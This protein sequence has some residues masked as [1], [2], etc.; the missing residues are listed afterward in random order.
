MYD[1]RNDVIKLMKE[2]SESNASLHQSATALS[3]LL[4]AYF[5][6]DENSAKK[7]IINDEAKKSEKNDVSESVSSV[8]SKVKIIKKADENWPKGYAKIERKLS[9]AIAND[10]TGKTVAYFRE[11]LCRDYDLENGDYVLLNIVYPY[12]P[13]APS[14]QR[15]KA[16]I[17]DLVKHKEPSSIEV[18]GPAVVQEKN[19]AGIKQKIVSRDINGNSLYDVSGVISY[20]I[21]SD[22]VNPGDS[23]VLAWY[24]GINKT[25][26]VRWDYSANDSNADFSQPK[27]HSYY[28]NKDS[29]KND[30][31]KPVYDFDLKHQKVA[32]VAADSALLK[33]IDKVVIS[34]NGEY[35][36]VSSNIASSALADKLRGYP[37]IIMIQSYLHHKDSGEI[38]KKLANDH[39]LAMATTA[40][41]LSVERAL[42]RAV[43]HLNIYDNN[44]DYF[45]Y[46]R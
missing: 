9:G 46:L 41:Q 27:A 6:Q 35:H 42:C 33:N 19:V 26:T 5:D 14:G 8:P 24:K 36:F 45:E 37:I 34:H 40:G 38:V 4:K 23:V 10:T 3:M 1:Y 29:V 44:V 32:V 22:F 43:N 20:A 39:M 25:M 13:D 17:N 28:A 31:Y 11:S 2:T 7:D 16:Y 15:G 18:F 30:V 12:N 21:N